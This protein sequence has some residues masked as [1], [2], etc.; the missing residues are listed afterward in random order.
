M[1][2]E[3]KYKQN[4]V[5]ETWKKETT[6]RLRH[7]LGFIV[8]IDLKMTRMMEWNGFIHRQV[9]SS[10]QQNNE[11]LF[12]TKYG[13]FLTIWELISFSSRT[14]LHGVGQLNSASGSALSERTSDIQDRAYRFDQQIS[15]M[16]QK[17]HCTL[18]NSFSELSEFYLCGEM[19]DHFAGPK[20]M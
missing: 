10:C 7:M 16:W 8:K 4:F 14:L 11:P 2:E 1:W 19:A 13:G 12:P 15:S 17:L 9:V 6:R 20:Q 5:G 3:Q 18:H